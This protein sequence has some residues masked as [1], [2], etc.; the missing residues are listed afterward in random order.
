[1][2]SSVP[3]GTPA[4]EAIEDSPLRESAAVDAST[5][6]AP[7]SDDEAELTLAEGLLRGIG[8]LRRGL[9]RCGPDWPF[10]PLTGAQA[11]LLR[12]VR[13]EPGISVT[14]AAA[15]LRV[16]P[17][18]VSTLV[19]HLSAAGLLRRDADASDR[20]VARLHLTATAERR[21]G[22]WR[23]RRA[24]AV[25]AGLR[26]LPAEQRGVLTDVVPALAALTNHLE[27]ATKRPGDPPLLDSTETPGGSR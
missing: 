22:A 2:V 19:R 25:A 23:D 27:A 9:L 4:Q 8:A 6:P 13:R 26:A 24:H 1:V 20:R 17:N 14:T 16:A 18:T 15:T 11:E 5:A 10:G 21:I 3:D 7:P 12:L